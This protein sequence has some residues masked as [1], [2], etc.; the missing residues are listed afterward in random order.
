MATVTGVIHQ[1][2]RDANVIGE[3]ETASGDIQTD[4]LDNLNQMLASWQL[5]NVNVYAQQDTSFTPN[6]AL[7]YSVGTGA[8]VNLARPKKIDYAYWTSGGIDYQI[9][10][11][12]T[13]EQYES[14]PQKTQ[15]GEPLYF[16][17]LPSYTNG[18]L[19]LYPQPSSGTMHIVTQVALPASNAIGDT[20]NLPPEYVLPVRL[21]LY[22][23]L[24]GVYGA[25]IKPALASQA[26]STFKA[27]KRN[28]LR[29]QP[30]S[31]PVAAQHRPNIF[32]GV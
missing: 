22:V 18:T 15:A 12:D 7:S 20:L 30:L 1:A 31:M 11:L 28:N 8:T 4:A 13:F 6:G 10:R 14:I 3:G 26:A 19:Y 21:N 32:S 29:I 2:L 16:F 27:L 23:L 5:D 9:T 24:A 25:P 17:Y